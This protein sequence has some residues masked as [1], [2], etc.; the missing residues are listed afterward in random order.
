VRYPKGPQRGKLLKRFAERADKQ[1]SKVDVLG[2]Q[3]TLANFDR[4]CLA[5]AETV[6]KAAIGVFGLQPQYD[7]RARSVSSPCI[8]ELAR[9][10]S[11]CNRSIHAIVAR[12]RPHFADK[13]WY[14]ALR[15]EF[16]AAMTPQ[17]PTFVA[18]AKALRNRLCT[19]L[20]KKAHHVAAERAQKRDQ[21]LLTSF[22]Q[23]GS[24]K[25]IFGP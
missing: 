10:I 24:A 17:L 25:K 1:I 11:P 3:V 9:K 22:M 12:Y 4:I 21:T 5:F 23:G 16:A 8:R 20:R 2:Q 13:A 15:A 18:A 14:R 7:G 19:E 6:N